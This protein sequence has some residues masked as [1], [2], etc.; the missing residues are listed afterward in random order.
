MPARPPILD[1]RTLNDILRQ[2]QHE[3]HNDVPE[4]EPLPAGDAGTMLQRI[5]ARLD[6]GGLGA[7][8][9]HGGA[10]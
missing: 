9:S 7:S 3:A 10:P 2:L 6:P 5:F 4:W 8:Q 1:S